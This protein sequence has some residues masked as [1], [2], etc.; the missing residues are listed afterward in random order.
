[1]KLS[2]VGRSEWWGIPESPRWCPREWDG[3][4][5]DVAEGYGHLGKKLFGEM[6]VA[7]EE[8][9]NFGS[10]ICHLQIVFTCHRR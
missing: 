3:L 1:M 6:G 2:H 5:R 8:N 9:I 7:R 4:E 10:K